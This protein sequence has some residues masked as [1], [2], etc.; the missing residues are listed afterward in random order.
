[1]TKSS[2]RR[3]ATVIRRRVASSHGPSDRPPSPDKETP[4]DATRRDAC[5]RGFT[6]IELMVVVS[7]IALLI[8]LLLAAVQ[9]AREASR[10]AQCTNNLKQLALAAHSYESANGCFPMGSVLKI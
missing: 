5:S 8:A 6:L 7:I 9:S 3:N 2:S 10:R 4:N 1:M